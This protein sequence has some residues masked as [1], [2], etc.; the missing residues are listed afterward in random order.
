MGRRS[1]IAAGIALGGFAATSCG[2]RPAQLEIRP[3]GV[4]RFV[5]FVAHN[6]LAGYQLDVEL[7][8]RETQG[9]D[10]ALTLISVGAIDKSTRQAFLTYVL[11]AGELRE[12]GLQSIDGGGMLRFRPSLG[13]VADEP[14]G[15][16]ELTLVVQGVD[17]RGNTASD[18]QLLSL[19]VEAP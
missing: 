18:F 8:I 7:A 9:V 15:P 14:R 3:A 19:D 12:P 5:P 13:L 17:A 6:V 4:A 2:N 16:V 1:L 10:V 11:R